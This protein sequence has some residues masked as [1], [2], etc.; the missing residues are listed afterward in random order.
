MAGRRNIW[1][2]CLIALVT[3]LVVGNFAN[4]AALD[5]NY[6]WDVRVN[7]AAVDA[8]V[9]GLD[10]YF[11]KNLKGS[12]YSYPYLPATLD[13]FRPLCAGGFL[14]GHRPFLLVFLRGFQCPL[15][16]V[17][18]ERFGGLQID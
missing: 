17:D 11:V 13:V 7:C 4:D 15:R 5:M 3:L 2:A 18:P 1:L 14:V 10:P 8:H 16:G 6:G 9:D 12:K